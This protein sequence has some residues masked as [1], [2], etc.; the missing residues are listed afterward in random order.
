TGA[1]LALIGNY[2]YNI[3]SQILFKAL[4]MRDTIP[5][6]VGMFQKE[7]A[8]RITAGPG[9]KDY[10]ILSVL[11][12]TWY[13]AE[14]LFTVDEHEFSPPPKVKSGVVRFKR[15]ALKSLICDEILYK[16]VIKTA[17]NQRRKQLKNSIKTLIEHTTLH[18]EL[19][20][21]RP[22]QLS[23]DDFIAITLKIQENS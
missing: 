9:N 17:F 4:E 5:E 15:N 13:D 10:G 22:E 14:Y 11:L 2:P 7:V 16:N 12:Q 18:E 6:I 21:K 8:M 23:V 19:L 1:K 3:S 20:M